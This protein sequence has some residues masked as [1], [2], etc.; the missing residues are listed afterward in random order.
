MCIKIVWMCFVFNSEFVKINE[1][2]GYL[3]PQAHSLTFVAQDSAQPLLYLSRGL[4]LSA[5][6]V[7]NLILANLLHCEVVGIRICEIKAAH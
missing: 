4:A 6:V 1:L 5:G 2:S 3:I 7:L